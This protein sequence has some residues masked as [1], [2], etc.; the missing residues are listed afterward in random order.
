MRGTAGRSRR[1]GRGQRGD[2]QERVRANVHA[3]TAIDLARRMVEEEDRSADFELRIMNRC[4]RQL[5]L[6]G[7][8]NIEYG[9]E[10]SREAV[11]RLDDRASELATNIRDT[12]AK[13]EALRREIQPSD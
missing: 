10:I 13:L 3:S 12:F 8:E 11:D 4:A 9:L 7:P 1:A 2:R 5:G 6:G